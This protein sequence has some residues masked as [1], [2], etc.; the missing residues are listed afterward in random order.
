MMHHP[1]GSLIFMFLAAIAGFLA[2][3]GCAM[4]A[5]AAG[6]ITSAPFG[7]TGDGTPV[8]IYTLRN[9]K[10][11]A[12]ICTYGGIVVSLN[13]P[14][15]DGHTGDVVLGFDNL[16]HYIQFSPF[17][18]SII[19][20]Y[21]NRI[22]KGK[23]TLDGVEYHLEINNAPNSLHGGNKGFDKVVWKA[24]PKETADGPALELSYLSPDGEEGY[25][26]NLKVKATYTLTKDSLRLD[27]EATTDKDTIINL[28][29]HTYFNLAGKG[30]I[31]RHEIFIPA[32]QFT[33]V[34]KTLIPTGELKSVAGTPFDFRQPIPIGEHIHD[35]NEQLKFGHGYDH[36]LVIAKPPG[37]LGLMGRVTDPDSGR[38]L[39]VLSTEPGVQFY[40][41][42]FLDGSING[43]NG[44]PYHFR[45]AFC[46]EPQHFPD[47][48]NHPGFPSVVLKPGEVY[49]NTIIYKFSVK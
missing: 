6:Q 38:V 12:R 44:H 7:K 23:F 27:F 14:D 10:M 46:L 29:Q 47:S 2:F 30:D 26:G 18:G 19:G 22:A 43:K 37:K 24:S 49:K 40:T 31:L 34:D 20:R 45:K 16:D 42:N 32:D 15:R 25:P 3:A 4:P 28:T 8:E 48:P 33:P 35:D 5:L 39:E 21:G 11:E 41:G 9:G 17:F 13:A 36:N 1:T